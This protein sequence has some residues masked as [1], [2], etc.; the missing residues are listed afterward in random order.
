MSL[1]I[2]SSSPKNGVNTGVA[3][4][5]QTTSFSNYFQSA[6]RIPPYS[7]IGVHS[8]KI[9]RNTSSQDLLFIRVRGLPIETYNGANSGMSQI[10]GVIPDFHNFGVGVKETGTFS[11]HGVNASQ[12]LV[13]HMNPP[14]YVNLNN[15]TELLLNEINAELVDANEEVQPRG[16]YDAR[17][18]IVLHIRQSTPS[19]EI[20]DRAR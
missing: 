4:D 2:L 17:S 13:H 11:E 8:V 6:I 19:R 16:E 9:N 5:N 14:L 20:R 10:L 1:V 12:S 3:N 7:Q 18:I 15:P